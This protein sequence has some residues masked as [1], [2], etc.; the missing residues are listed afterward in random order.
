M[1]TS[2]KL[3]VA[4]ALAVFCIGGMGVLAMSSDDS[5]AEPVNRIS[6]L[7][8]QK[9]VSYT[10]TL[11]WTSG[12]YLDFDGPVPNIPGMT[13][14]IDFESGW[15]PTYDKRYLRLSGTPTVPGTYEV[16]WKY[17]NSLGLTTGYSQATILVYEVVE[18]VDIIYSA[19]IGTVK[20]SNTWSEHIVKGSNAS[21]PAASYSTGA[22][23]FKGW[24]TTPTSSTVVSSYKADSNA[25]LYAVWTQNRV[26]ISGDTNVTVVQGSALNQKYS[27]TPSG[28]TLTISSYGG[29]Q[30]QVSLS[31]KTLVGNITADPGTYYVTLSA[32]SSGYLTGTLQVKITVPV[33]IVEPIQ[34]SQAVNTVWSYE[35]VTT[36]TNASISI[37]S[38]KFNGTTVSNHGLTVQGRTITGS[39]PNQG[40][41]AVEFTATATGYTS[42]SKTVLVYTYTPAPSPPPAIGGISATERVGEPRTYDFIATGVSNSVLITW[43]VDGVEFASSHTTAVY[44]FM[45]AGVYTIKA[46][47]LG[48][49]GKTAEFSKQVVCDQS[50]NKD[51]AWSGVEYGYI[52]GYSGTAPAV[53]TSGPFSS[54]FET[55]GGLSYVHI[56]GTPSAG[57]VGK[58][59]SVSVGSDTWYVAV[60]SQES[61]APVSDFTYSISEDYTLTVSFSGSHAS[62]VLWDYGNGQW[63]TSTSKSFADWGY[64]SVRCLAINNISE[65][66]CTQSVEI[67]IPDEVTF[68]WLELKD[69]YGIVDRPIV[70]SIT[71]LAETDTLA[72][73]GSAAQY[74]S[75]SGHIITGKVTAVGVYGLT[76][77]AT[78]QDSTVT[79]HSIVMYIQEPPPM[80]DEDEDGDGFSV[81][82]WI[83][84]GSVVVLLLAFSLRGRK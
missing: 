62:K 74:L 50:Y 44:E 21:L 65:R 36:P 17:W 57:D 68:S 28:A 33:V 48:S 60:Y 40:T 52:K 63:V 84:L 30:G 2:K 37:K 66:I 75:V 78:H 16:K 38:V 69:Y 32:S 4:L 42:V 11:D 8:L 53:K 80:D 31:S 3:Y 9:G 71:G 47:V 20:G 41:Y 5:S 77:A 29:L 39:L 73:S 18:Y 83:V 67:A 49:D 27:T 45:S 6:H 25:T 10:Y 26:S 72:I 35:P 12:M 64:Y 1:R 43:Y 15:I 76:L 58:S 59:F 22:Y 19:G 24:A 34:Y 79:S 7:E 46:V 14:K 70:I 54:S 13:A 23:S 51:M 81:L 82:L 61:V 56:K 55:I